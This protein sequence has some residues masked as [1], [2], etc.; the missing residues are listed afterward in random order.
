MRR[1]AERTCC[2]GQDLKKSQAYTREFGTAIQRVLADNLHVVQARQAELKQ[3]SEL[4]NISRVDLF[5][6]GSAQDKL[7]D[8]VLGPCFKA[9]LAKP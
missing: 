1:C 3:K 4:V 8:V 6:D 7:S 5:S 2:R 9:L